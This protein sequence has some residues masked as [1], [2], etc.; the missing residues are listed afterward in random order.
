MAVILLAQ[1]DRPSVDRGI[2]LARQLHVAAAFDA[3]AG[4]AASGSKLPEVRGAAIDACVANDAARALPV[5]RTVLT[6][7]TEAIPLRQKAATVMAAMNL[8][9]ARHG[10]WPKN[11]GPRRIG[12]PWKSGAGWPGAPKGARH[13]WPR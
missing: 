2:E 1:P 3:L 9:D 8:A 10:G 4:L 13:Y 5:A 6:D 12:S 11:C 7:A